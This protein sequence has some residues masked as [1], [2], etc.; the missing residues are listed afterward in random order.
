MI[1][2][3]QFSLIE[4]LVVIGILGALCT[5]VLPGFE[6][7]EQD[8][9][10]KVALTEMRDIQ[11]TFRKFAMDTR[12][13]SSTDKMRDMVNF[14]LWPLLVETQ[15]ANIAVNIAYADYDPEYEIG[16]RGP[17]LHNEGFVNTAAATNNS[18]QPEQ[19]GGT[20]K[21]PVLKDPYGG[22]YRVICPEFDAVNDSE[23]LLRKKLCRMV[24]VCTG[25]DC[26]LDTSASD[27]EDNNIKAQGDDR[28]VRL[29]PFA[30]Y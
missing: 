23:Q 20:V 17:Y 29:M 28:L 27:I 19:I 11:S 18:G 26:Q 14:G 3:K 15:P 7:A 30:A 6:G 10:E 5:L 22:Y 24:L 21:I 25:S 9:R 2:T 13:K 16:R 4:L 1:Y 12:L 8:A